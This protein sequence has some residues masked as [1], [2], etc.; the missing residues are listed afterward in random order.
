MRR[1]I[2]CVREVDVRPGGTWRYVLVIPNGQ[3]V[4]FKGVYHE[5][6]PPERLVAPNAMTSRAWDARGG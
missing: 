2:L 3:E 1:T 6:T 5:I 4:K